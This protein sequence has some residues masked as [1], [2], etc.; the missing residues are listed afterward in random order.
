MIKR[1]Y[2]CLKVIA[3]SQEQTVHTHRRIIVAAGHREIFIRMSLTYN[4]LHILTASVNECYSNLL[5]I[6]ESSAQ[7][8]VQVV[9]SSGQAASACSDVVITSL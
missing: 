4:M 1:I 9:N 2:I 5:R 8:I 6:E 3:I 7:V